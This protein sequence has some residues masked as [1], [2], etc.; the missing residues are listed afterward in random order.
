[1]SSVYRAADVPPA[2]RLDYLRHVI[3]RTLVP[4][5]HRFDHGPEFDCHLRF[6]ELGAVR[7][8]ESSAGPGAAVRTGRLIRSSDPEVYLVG[9]VAEG[10]LLVEQDERQGVLR[11]GDLTLFDSSRP[12]RKLYSAMRTV[13][14]SFPHRLL[15][16]PP[17]EVRRLTAVRFAGDEGVGSVVSTLVRDTA[18]RM[19]DVSPAEAGRFG[20][21]VLD[22]LTVL[23][24]SRLDRAA[25]VPHES[26]RRALLRQVY[27]FLDQHMDDPALDPGTVAA[28]HHISVRALHKLFENEPRSL[29]AWIRT[30]R[31][32]RCRRDLLD[33][34]L[35][36][37]PVGAIAAD[38]GLTNQAH[39]SRL[40][41]DAYGCSPTEL[42]RQ[43]LRQP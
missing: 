27:A 38:H 28:A 19:D 13:V 39:F 12:G 6:G 21:A 25:D 7:I 9:V 1:M 16:L 41:R 22:L 18:S 15:P 43:A 5:E 34:A 4:Q 26:G 17:D 8:T 36:H 3:G 32:D 23:F 24:A 30:A 33:P 14:V 35:A 31:L 11:P 42:R 40:F 2:T 10:R 29:A 37:R 20:R